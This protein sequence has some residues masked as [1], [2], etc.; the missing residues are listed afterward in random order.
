MRTA[1]KKALKSKRKV[2]PIPKCFK[3]ENEAAEF[4][5]THSVADYWDEMQEAHFEIEID[6]VPQAVALEYPV[7]RKLSKVARRENQPI[8]ALVNLLMK[9]WLAQK[10]MAKSLG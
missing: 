2:E 9:D 8:D 1:T 4:W 6:E 10:P 7:A 3:N 5:E